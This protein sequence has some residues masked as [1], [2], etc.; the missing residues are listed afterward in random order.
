MFSYDY[1]VKIFVYT[2]LSYGISS[3][4][5]SFRCWLKMVNYQCYVESLAAGNLRF[6][7]CC[8]RVPC[9]IFKV[10]C[11]WYYYW[12]AHVPTW[13]HCFPVSLIATKPGKKIFSN[14]RTKFTWSA[15]SERWGNLC[16]FTLRVIN[17]RIQYSRLILG[18]ELNLSFRRDT[19]HRG[20]WSFCCC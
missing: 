16:S 17:E 9:S 10:C 3:V 5:V 12:F 6:C 18:V 15:H 4:C 13:D 19:I 20:L 1:F 7:Y 8:C 2:S 14:C 11:R